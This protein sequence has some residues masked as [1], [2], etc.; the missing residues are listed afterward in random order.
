MAVA[1]RR[2]ADLSAHQTMAAEW[3]RADSFDQLVKEHQSLVAA[4]MAQRWESALHGA[5]VSGDVLAKARQSPEWASLLSALRDADYRSLDVGSALSEVAKLEM[6]KLKGPRRRAPGAPTA[7]GETDRRPVGPPPGPG[8][9]PGPSSLGDRRPRPRPSRRRARRR[10]HQAGP[11]SGRT[12]RARWCTLGPLARR[13]RARSSPRPGGTA[14]PSSPPTGTV[15]VSPTQAPS[16]TRRIWVHSPKPPTAPGRNG[17]AR[18]RLAWPAWGRR[19]Q[20][21]PTVA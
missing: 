17:P 9:R 19:P 5:G 20:P 10:H 18:K 15:G 11:G 16:A 4:A 12:C 21:R 7:L 1:S 14:S 2:G 3:A 13:P 8:G 6:G